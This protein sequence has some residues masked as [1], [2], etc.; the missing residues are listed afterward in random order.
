MAAADM[1]PV[2]VVGAGPTGLTAA[3]ELSRF[4]IPVR[5]IEKQTQARTTSRAIGVQARTLE[6]FE[7]RGFAGEFLSMGNQGIGGNVYGGGERIAHLDFSQI[8]SRYGFV[9]LI[10]QAETEGIL[11]EQLFRQNVKVEWGVELVAFAESENVTAT[12]RH[13]DGVLE[14]VQ[15]SYLDQC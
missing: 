4:G 2:L 10:S 3:M 12:L 7:Q 5:L 13:S 1:K 11:R 9:L 15:A 14:E 8:D 6:L